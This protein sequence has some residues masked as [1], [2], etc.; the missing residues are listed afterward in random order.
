MILNYFRN[1]RTR[2]TLSE[3]ISMEAVE[4]VMKGE[5]LGTL[6]LRSARMEIVLVLVRGETAEAVSERVGRVA[7][8]AMKQAAVIHT[9]ISSLVVMTCGMPPAH[10]TAAE[11]NRFSLVRELAQALGENIKIVHSSRDCSYG[12]VGGPRRFFHTFITAD[13]NQILAQLSSAEF[14]TCRNLDG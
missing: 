9:I 14:G 12:N 5:L 11:G 7:D 4:S 3:Y 1:R 8:I 13:L 2:K 10:P 6:G